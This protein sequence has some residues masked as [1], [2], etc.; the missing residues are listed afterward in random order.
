MPFHNVIGH[1]QK[2]QSASSLQKVP[3]SKRREKK[4][5]FYLKT[6]IL[7]EKIYP[8]ALCAFRKHNDLKKCFLKILLQQATAIISIFSASIVAT[9]FQPR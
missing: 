6:I 7:G 9:L 4:K 8:C 1:G 2:S 5:S 3:A